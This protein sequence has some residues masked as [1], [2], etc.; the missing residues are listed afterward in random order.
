MTNWLTQERRDTYEQRLQNAADGLVIDLGHNEAT[1]SFLKKEDELDE[2]RFDGEGLSEEYAIKADYSQIDLM[3]MV[4]I[5]DH[6]SFLIDVS[7][8]IGENPHG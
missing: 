8:E 7:L 3:T 1:T 4:A 5:A 6:V 2:V